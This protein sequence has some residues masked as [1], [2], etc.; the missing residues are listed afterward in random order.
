MSVVDQN[1]STAEQFMMGNEAIARGAL[2]SGVHFAAGYPG[3]PSSEIIQYC[4]VYTCL[5]YSPKKY[6]L[7]ALTLDLAKLKV[8]TANLAFFGVP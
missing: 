5:I 6:R 1:L 8:T 4:A 2:E 7:L 3:T